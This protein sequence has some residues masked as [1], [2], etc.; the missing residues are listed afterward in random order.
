MYVQTTLAISSV[1]W[2]SHHCSNDRGIVFPRPCAWCTCGYIKFWHGVIFSSENSQH[3]FDW[4][5]FTHVIHG[6]AF[7]F[8][9]WLIDRKKRLSF[10]AK[11][12]LATGL[13]A[14]WEILEN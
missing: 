5:S 6:F 11:L 14:S 10:T 13:E 4:Y 2:L 12:L 3:L 7:Y 1:D 9:L 8:L